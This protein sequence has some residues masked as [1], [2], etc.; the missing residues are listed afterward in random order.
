MYIEIVVVF[1]G[2]I[3]RIF[4]SDQ[5]FPARKNMIYI[6]VNCYNYMRNNLKCFDVSSSLF[7]N[8]SCHRF[9]I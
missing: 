3:L 2:S 6:I 1:G 8:K 7:F 5:Q 4:K 9:L